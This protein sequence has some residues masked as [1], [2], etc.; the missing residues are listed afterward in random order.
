[1]KVAVITVSD[2][3]SQNLYEDKSGPLIVKMLK[4]QFPKAAI[5]RMTVPDDKDEIMNS[6]REQNDSDYIF[7][8]GGTGLSF[9]DVTPDVTR[10]FCEKPVPGIAEVLRAQSYLETPHA[11]LSRGFAGVKG[12]TIVVNFPGSPK[13]AEMC[14]KLL[15]PVMIHGM[16]MLRGEGHD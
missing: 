3:A 5:V 9:R 2:R 14:T 12:T 4:E 15:M 7:T 1:M 11:M 10:E 6:L 16:N 8:C 13:A